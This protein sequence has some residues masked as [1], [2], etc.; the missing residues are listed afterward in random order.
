MLVTAPVRVLGAAQTVA[1]RPE[2][3]WQV[4]V[5]RRPLLT[6]SVRSAPTSRALPAFS[7]LPAGSSS[8]PT[9]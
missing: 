1:A 6:T 3:A 7:G 4:G 9:E 2:G 5:G 8:A